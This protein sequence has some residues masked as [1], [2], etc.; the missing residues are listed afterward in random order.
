[1]FALRQKNK[2][3]QL[4]LGATQGDVRQAHNRN[5]N[6][7]VR[8][9]F[10][11]MS[12]LRY[13]WRFLSGQTLHELPPWGNREFRGW[14]CLLV[15]RRKRPPHPVSSEDGLP[16]RKKHPTLTSLNQKLHRQYYRRL[17]R[18]CCS[19]RTENSSSG[20]FSDAS[21]ISG[22]KNQTLILLFVSSRLDCCRNIAIAL[23]RKSRV[24]HLESIGVRNGF[25]SPWVGRRPWITRKLSPSAVVRLLLPFCKVCQFLSPIAIL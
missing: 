13:A 3:I 15:P 19:G 25:S 9:Q 14:Y 17:H 7:Q 6:E 22:L 12:Q 24:T 18:N 5:G 20:E 23:R 10:E 2:V 8:P 4:S 1:M 11:N 16:V 21:K